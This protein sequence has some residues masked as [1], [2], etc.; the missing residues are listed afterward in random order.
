MMLKSEQG[1]TLIEALCAVVV[2]SLTV[3]L[4]A[5]LW[6]TSLAIERQTELVAA[7]SR[8]SVTK[9]ERLRAQTSVT[10][11]DDTTSLEINGTTVTER[12]IIK[13]EDGLYRVTLTYTWQE[14]GHT[15]EQT[16]ATDHP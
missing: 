13:P 9:L 7:L 12:L 3:L 4:A 11:C 1:F 8:Q 10:L 2:T 6:Q 14:R 16:W 15:R 5:K